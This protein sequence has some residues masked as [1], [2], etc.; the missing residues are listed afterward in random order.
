MSGI[1]LFLVEPKELLLVDQAG[2]LQDFLQLRF[3]QMEVNVFLGCQRLAVLRGELVLANHW[4]NNV[5][6]SSAGWQVELLTRF[7]DLSSLQTL[8][9]PLD[10]ET[11]IID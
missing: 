1:L 6:S 3:H 4:R 2:I 8:P 11:G 9:R 7:G 10:L 5:L